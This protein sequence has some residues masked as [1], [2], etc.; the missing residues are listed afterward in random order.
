MGVV[1]QHAS[2]NFEMASW[3]KKRKRGGEREDG[4]GFR[5]E[6][7][8]H[9]AHFPHDEESRRDDDNRFSSEAEISV[10]LNFRMRVLEVGHIQLPGSKIFLAIWFGICQVESRILIGKKDLN[11]PIQIFGSDPPL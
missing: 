10:L 8:S 9:P 3:G 1:S 6:P 2:D 4:W 5:L 11:S 7:L